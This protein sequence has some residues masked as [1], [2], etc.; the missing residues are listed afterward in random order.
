MHSQNKIVAYTTK[1]RPKKI[2]H[3][4]GRLYAEICPDVLSANGTPPEGVNFVDFLGIYP[5]RDSV[6]A[7]HT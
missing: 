3:I 1:K 5:S 7:K 2:R 4:R 6:R